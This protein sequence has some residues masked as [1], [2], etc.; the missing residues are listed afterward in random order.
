MVVV[1]AVRKKMTWTMMIE[2]QVEVR[3]TGHLT[4]RVEVQCEQGQQGAWKG[5]TMNVKV[6]MVS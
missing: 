3:M 5:M 6:K 2:V 1:V 4:G